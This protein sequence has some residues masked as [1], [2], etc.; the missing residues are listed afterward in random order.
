MGISKVWQWIQDKKTNTIRKWRSTFL[1]FGT[2]S[3]FEGGER[4]FA[5][6]LDVPESS[7]KP[8]GGSCNALTARSQS[9][10]LQRRRSKKEYK[11]RRASEK[12]NGF[13]EPLMVKY[14]WE[15][16]NAT[17]DDPSPVSDSYYGQSP[18]SYQNFDDLYGTSFSGLDDFNDPSPSFINQ[19]N[20]YEE[21]DE[22]FRV[23][24]WGSSKR[25]RVGN[26]TVSAL[27]RGSEVSNSGSDSGKNKRKLRF[28][29]P[30]VG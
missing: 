24:S 30:E 6:E 3:T 16:D 5:S 8:I 23:G 17:S 25:D 15:Q 19:E 20:D 4:Y 7:L 11:N 29:I 2:A 14:D 18:G 26:P 1:G 10:K 21:F 27:R 9:E 13:S 28:N 22:D 12:S